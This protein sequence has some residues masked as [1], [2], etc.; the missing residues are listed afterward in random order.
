EYAPDNSIS[1]E[2]LNLNVDIGDVEIKYVTTPVEF[3]VKIQVDIEMVGQL[4]A[5]K[6]YSDYFS[7]VWDI[8]SPSPTF[9]MLFTSDT[10]FDP[11]ILLTQYVDIVITLNANILFDINITINEK[12]NVHLIVPYGVTTNNVDIYT[13][14]GDVL[15]DFRYCTLEGNIIGIANEGNIELM[16]YAS[17]FN[18]VDGN[19]NVGNILYDFQYCTLEGNITGIANEGDIDLLACNPE[20]TRNTAWTY[21]SISGDITIDIIHSNHSKIMN[22]TITGSVVGNDFGHTTLN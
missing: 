13:N 22:A 2:K 4:V 17:T 21:N 9:T 20:Y 8:T 18:N 3:Y 11:S 7:V 15:Y 12:G 19:T 16:A 5:G 1:I 10:W 14:E 6:K